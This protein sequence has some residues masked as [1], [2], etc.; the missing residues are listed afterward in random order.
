MA[1]QSSGDLPADLAST[2]VNQGILGLFLG[3][4]WSKYRM[5]WPIVAVHGAVNAVPILLPLL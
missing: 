4:L 2:F 1:I 3:Y 5:M